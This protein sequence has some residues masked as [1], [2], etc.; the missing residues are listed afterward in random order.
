MNAY[1]AQGR[2]LKKTK[3]RIALAT[4]QNLRPAE[5]DDEPYE[6]AL[7]R[8]GLDVDVIPWSADIDWS[9]YD[10]VQLRTTWDYTEHIEAFLKWANA[11]SKVTRLLNPFA[12][13]KWNYDKN[14]LKEVDWPLVKTTWLKAGDDFDAIDFVSTSTYF[15]KPVIGANARNTLRFTG[16]KR[17]EARYFLNDIWRHQ[18]T[19]GFMC[20]SY[21][22]TVETFGEVSAIVIDG[23]Y[24]HGVRKVPVDGDYRVQDDHGAIDMPYAFEPYQVEKIICLYQ[25]LERRFEDLFYARF[26]FLKNKQG[27]LVLNEVELIEPSLFFRHA[28]ES[29]DLMAARLIERLTIK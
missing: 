27:D 29:A 5:C 15:L 14:Y 21:L 22:D 17:H 8:E 1:V 25:Q 2:T 10:A 7:R 13:V 28:P 18:P 16:A 19:L 20:Q 9:I 3:F 24:A 12:V 11:T 6:A 23:R 26:D 4:C